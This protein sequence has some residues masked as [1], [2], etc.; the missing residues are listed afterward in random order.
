MGM[1][2]TILI[3]CVECGSV[4]ECQSKSGEC[5]LQTLTLEEAVETQDESLFDVNR[6][7]PHE[8]PE[9]GTKNI[10][11]LKTTATVEK[12]GEG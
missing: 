5:C 2:D 4:I 10:V 1:F 11:K 12:Y 7:A 3:R 6:H 8:C 9:C